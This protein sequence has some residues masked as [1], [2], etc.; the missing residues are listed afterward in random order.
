MIRMIQSMSS[1]AAKS[2]FSDSLIKADYYINDQEL[3]GT[4][5]GKMMPRLGLAHDATKEQFFDL[6][7]NKN[8]KDQSQ[9]TAR[10]KDLR[11]VGYDINFHCPKSMSIVHA[12]SKDKHIMDIFQKSVRETMIEIEK[13]VGTRIRK[14]GQCNNRKTG[15]LVWA[16]FIHQ[17]ARPT[18]DHDP[19][20]HLHAHCFVFN[21]TWDEVEKEFKAGQFG[22]IKR[23]MPYYQA[24]FHKMMSDKL[25]ESGYQIKRTKGS[26]EI[27]GVPQQV[28]DHFS[29][30]TNE[31]GQIAEEQGITSAKDLDGLGARTRAR[32]QKGKTMEELR[33]DWKA[34]IKEL[35]RDPNE[36]YERII[37]V[38]NP[39]EQ[40][41][42]TIDKTAARSVEHAIQH[43]FE[44]ASVM[45][46]RKVLAESYRYAMGEVNM[47]VQGID[48]A[49]KAHETL[50]HLKDAGRDVVTTETVLKEE[51][52]MVSLAK[53]G[54]GA[55]KPLY[56]EIPQINLDGQQKEAVMDVLTNRNR[57]SII[58]GAAGSGKTRLMTEAVS[59]MKQAGKTV[60][61]LA[62]TA[63]ASRGV[64]KDEGFDGAETVAKFL[65]DK[66]LQQKI[67]DQILW[68]D[69]AG[70]LGTEDMT[71]ILEISK[72]MNARVILG[73]DT[74]QHSSVVRGD[75]LR[76]LN[77]VGNIRASEVNRI[78]RQEVL[79]YREAIE[80]LAQGAIRSGFDRLD[81]AG[82]IKEIDPMNPNEE[83]VNDYV[84]SIIKGKSALVISP[85]HKQGEKLTEEI[86]KTLRS[87]RI[88][89]KREVAVARYANANLTQAQKA[90]IR[91]FKE[92]QVIQF[93]QNVVGFPKGTLWTVK[94]LKDGEMVL[95]GQHDGQLAT[96]P[97]DGAKNY[98][99][100]DRFEI[101]LS[102]GDRVLVTKNSMDLNK[103]R[104]DNGSSLIVKHVRKNGHMVLVN[105][106]SKKE[107]QVKNDFGHINHAHVITS[108]ASQGKTVDEIFIY[109]PASTFPATDAKQ[110]YVSASRGR[111]RV[112]I[113]TE[114]KEELLRHAEEIG[115][116][117]S[118]MELM[119]ENRKPNGFVWSNILTSPMI[120]N[121]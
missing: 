66:D 43:S 102:H 68:I 10:T 44:R 18:E 20:P 71:H 98:D 79:S 51:R 86:R 110:F 23:D 103:T 48:G 6:C 47:T 15:E 8:P 109:Q 116:R 90:D 39:S 26:F 3:K 115:D 99:V 60:T 33:Q 5:H 75:A 4:F 93:N 120:G 22:D 34:Q 31:I 32:K 55:V 53:E 35:E 56:A 69:E 112:S 40:I 100:Y 45:P 11:R 1:G 74:R 82:F 14:K 77:S 94:Q 76:I 72:K 41:N 91:N 63:Q 42:K 119:N 37:R 117:K 89:G 121:R 58:R 16:E 88:I 92:G 118:A 107:Y 27:V 28:I 83:L 95:M 84:N 113:Y 46:T 9:L 19:D 111:T 57:V 52:Y 25:I 29:K 36:D 13:D 73:G 114:D 50:I 59:K 106:I 49:L 12:F 85:T 30:R 2:Y 7:E 101:G 96:L 108:Y 62:P 70:L 105:P 97:K 78:Y 81:N 24:R 21:A 61:V 104:M 65:I 38:N 87:K 80:D 64:L 67:K 17:T 54:I